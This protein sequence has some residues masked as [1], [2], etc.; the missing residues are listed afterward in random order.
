MRLYQ[1]KRR[2]DPEKRKEDSDRMREIRRANPEMTKAI[3]KKCYD[4]DPEKKKAR[5][6]KWRAINS[7]RCWASHTI[8]SHKRKG[9]AVIIT[10]DELI[11]KAKEI[12]TCLYCGRLID[13][14]S[15]NGLNKNS[16]SLDRINNGKIM[17]MNNIQ[18]ICHHCNA[19][20][21]S[22][23]HDEFVQ[24]CTKIYKQFGEIN[25]G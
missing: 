5:S 19:S 11:K 7:Q 24:Y 20:K 3:N 18:I 25:E 13:Y 22:R 1:R 6:K 9:Y 10:I 12:K 2:K 14:T 15:G 23:T 21:S 4:K 8:S 17:E 16:P